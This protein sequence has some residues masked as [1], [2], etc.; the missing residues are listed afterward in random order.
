LDRQVAISFE[1]NVIKVV[2]AS[3]RKG[4]TVV[5]RTLFLK[6][7]E[8]DSFLKTTRLSNL[9]VICHFQRFYSNIV[10]A[11]P[12]KPAYLK[13]IVE[14]EIKKSF[15]E[16]GSFSL[17]Y[18]VLKEKTAEE[19]GLK[20]VFYFAI[21]NSELYE[22]IERFNRHGQ[23]VKY[24][25]PD[26]LPLSKLIRSSDELSKKTVLCI[27]TSET[28]KPLFL[29]KNGQ[30]RFIRIIK[31]SGKDIDDIDVENINMTV[32]YCTQVLKLNPEQILLMN[33]P[34]RE[35]T[36]PLQTIVPVVTISYPSNV[37]AS[38]E[39]LRNF[40]TPL[41]SIIFNHDL[42]NDN[43]LPSKYRTLHLQKRMAAYSTVLFLLFSFI[44]LGYL[45][46]NLREISILKKNI[47]SLRK[48][49]TEIESIVPAYEKDSEKL[50]QLTPLINL[51]NEAHSI[52]DIPK[53]LAALK[54]LPLENTN[55][56]NIQINNKKDSLQIQIAGS[57]NAKNFG[58]MHK[59]FQELVKSFGQMPGTA[60]TSKSI[61]IRNN[62][63]QI[64]IESKIL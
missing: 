42:K 23:T 35:E 14:A 1:D 49:V 63:F 62:K 64:D 20:S 32:S 27:A 11:P 53:T 34:E 47:N 5:Q 28:E 52:P 6:D 39:T 8:F 17:F 7:E 51:I 40:I 30:L 38:Q 24:M 21:A 12:A 18:A 15:P 25:Y 33:V 10:S 37:L 36:D 48:D 55:I 3:S 46:M 31:S 50:Q 9:T 16:L 44:G 22:I 41:S 13:K 60:V 56:Q 45:L 57:I 43:L 29:L 19:K 58:D 54:F 4:K 26:I 2:F 59:I 61:D